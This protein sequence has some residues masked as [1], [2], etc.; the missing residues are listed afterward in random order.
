MEL[1]ARPLAAATILELVHP[2]LRAGLART[3]PALLPD[4]PVDALTLRRIDATLAP[5]PA[6][7]AVRVEHVRRPGMQPLELRVHGPLIEDAAPEMGLPVLLWIHGGGTIFGSAAREDVFC[8]DL[9]ERLGA[10]VVAVEYRLAPE[11][12]YPAA[13]DDCTDALAWC[14][15]RSERIV[16]AGGSAGGGLAAALAL[17]TR[18][19][20]GPAIAAQH[21]YYPMLDDRLA[22]ASARRLAEAPVCDRRIVETAWSAYLAGRPADPYAAP[23]RAIDLSGLPRS[24][25]DTGDLDL[26]MDEALDYARR[27]ADSGVETELHVIER[28]VHAF[29]LIAPEALLS[30]A[31]TARRIA[32]LSRDLHA[33]PTPAA[34]H[35]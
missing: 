32:A 1:D 7:T 25:V 4:G 20:G 31:A 33:E 15:A 11:H 24:Y 22:T 16:V 6:A 12:P 35:T 34:Q 3:L 23:A 29:E 10:A 30:R 21:L 19:E 26:F 27:L 14:G 8:S 5:A 28:A 2:D 13:L 9:A 18:D 17:R